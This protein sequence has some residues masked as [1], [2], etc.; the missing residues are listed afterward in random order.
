MEKL[1]HKLRHHAYLILEKPSRDHKFAR[2]LEIGLIVLIIVNVGAVALETV[3]P[4]YRKH[5]QLFHI[6]DLFTV[7][8]FTIEYLGR[9]WA[10]AERQP[11]Q[12]AARARIN[13]LISPI[14][15]VDLAAILPFY[16]SLFFPIHLDALRMLRLARIYKLMR[17][18]PAL[19]VLVAVIR[20]E[21][22]TLMAAFSILTILLV[23]AATGAY[24]VEHVAQPENF[25]SIPEATWWALVTLTTVGY[26][27][28]TP[29][30]VAGRIFGGVVTV[31]GVGM[32][33]LPAGILASGMADH[34]N[35]RRKHLRNQFRLALEDGRID[36]HEGR[37]IERLRRELG[38]SVEMAHAI[39]AEVLLKVHEHANCTCPNC[40]HE[41]D[42]AQYKDLPN[43]PA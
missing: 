31:L 19:S 40:G 37:E 18:S 14:A 11:G 42:A 32:A 34:L 2:I 43:K 12:S 30:T 26:G 5:S 25:G 4:L 15:L 20:E 3:E 41:F 22:A 21:A 23:F 9:A 16:L 13:Y 1:H 8:I 36:I 24:Y 29:I 7:V 17:Y 10:S 35:R 6:F 38:I 33:A 39:H 28:V 27:D